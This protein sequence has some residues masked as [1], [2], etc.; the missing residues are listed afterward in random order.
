MRI[1]V[2][3]S[4]I[5]FLSKIGKIDLLTELFDEILIP[6]N[7]F[8]ETVTQGREKMLDD[9]FVIENF[10]NQSSKVKIK[11]A[12]IRWLEDLPVGKGE[13]A[14]ISLAR[15]EGIDNVLIDESKARTLAKVFKLKPRGT[16]WVL[17]LAN[18]KGMITRQEF[19][20]SVL[21]VVEKGYRIKEEILAKFL[22]DIERECE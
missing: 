14:V 9:A 18:S 4:P 11:D 8:Y 10:I 2:D 12:D 15:I 21:R 7:V 6:S 3:S 20:E 22:I 5:I 1:V 13:K 17:S 19:K 16:L